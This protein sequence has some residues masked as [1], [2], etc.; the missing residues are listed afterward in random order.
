MT[1]EVAQSAEFCKAPGH[2][3]GEGGAWNLRSIGETPPGFGVALGDV[4]NAQSFEA[5][6][7]SV[8]HTAWS[9]VTKFTDEAYHGEQRRTAWVVR[10]NSSGLVA[11]LQRSK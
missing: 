7:P 5:L 10:R 4:Q 6:G 8:A 1:G 11:S 2:G 3:R 9:S